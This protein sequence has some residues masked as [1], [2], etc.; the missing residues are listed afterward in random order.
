MPAD[1]RRD[2]INDML[3]LAKR[4]AGIPR[5]RIF[6]AGIAVWRKK[7]GDPSPG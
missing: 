5:R 4:V 1:P 7:H 2:G 3:R 6:G